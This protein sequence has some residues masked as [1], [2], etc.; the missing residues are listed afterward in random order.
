MKALIL[1]LVLAAGAAHAAPLPD[2]AA[3]ITYETR[4]V[5]AEGVT[6]QTA[7]QERWVRSRD[8]VWSERVVPANA[9]HEHEAND[10]HEHDLNFATAAK[11]VYM[12]K[13]GKP[14]LQFV[15]R[16]QKTIIRMGESE[17]AQFGFDGSWDSSALLIDRRQ[18]ANM[19]KIA[20][21]ATEA[22][23][24]WLEQRKGEQYIRVLW[25]ETRQMPLVIESGTQD[26]G[27]WSRLTMKPQAMP[28]VLPWTQLAGYVRK[29]YMDLLD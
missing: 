6:K 12:E 27:S 2:A 9:V 8:H 20:K 7:F 14:A 13:G 17:Y 15:R 1:S 25:S 16:P 4:V 18:L 19:R 23:A 22:G 11:H 10:G 3:L 29:D 28:A 26:G 24:S 21:P 5:S